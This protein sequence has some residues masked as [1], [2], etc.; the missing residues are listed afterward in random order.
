MIFYGLKEDITLSIES[1]GDI[2]KMSGILKLLGVTIVKRLR[3]NEQW[4]QLF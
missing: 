3:F 4:L 1:N 2:V